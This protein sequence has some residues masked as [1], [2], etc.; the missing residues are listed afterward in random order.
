MFYFIEA[1]IKAATQMGLTPDQ[2]RQLALATFEGATALAQA[3]QEPV[4]VLRD[5]VTS[6]GGTTFAAL[7]VLS[8]AKVQDLFVQAM[9]AAR[10][11]SEQLASAASS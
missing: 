11:R 10:E 6:K 8:D 2:G 1:M 3:S 4:E 7:S 9:M 5:R